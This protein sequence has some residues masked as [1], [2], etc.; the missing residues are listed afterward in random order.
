MIRLIPISLYLKVPSRS[1][2]LQT[3]FFP[4]ILLTKSR[5]PRKVAAMAPGNETAIDYHHWIN[6]DEETDHLKYNGTD[7]F[8]HL[9]LGCP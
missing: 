1:S 5:N 8:R 3:D 4:G 9:P 2:L 6:N 7:L